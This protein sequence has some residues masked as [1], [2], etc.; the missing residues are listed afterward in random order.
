MGED[1]SEFRYKAFISYAHSD[2]HWA[3][4]LHRK[5]ENFRP[6]GHDGERWPLRPIFLDRSELGSSPDLSES[7]EKALQA[8]DA[9]IVVCSPAAAASRWVNEEIREF[10]RLGR[11][12]RLAAENTVGLCAFQ[13]APDA[14]HAAARR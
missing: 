7:I 1:R 11:G 8:S 3:K 12:E 4:R 10:R 14:P 6:P 9:L 2:A 5:L 13:A